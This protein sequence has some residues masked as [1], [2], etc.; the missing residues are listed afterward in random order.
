MIS[1]VSLQMCQGSF[2]LLFGKIK[3]FKNPMDL[4]FNIVIFYTE[5]YLSFTLHNSAG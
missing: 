3:T 1:L 2:A 5:F 4:V